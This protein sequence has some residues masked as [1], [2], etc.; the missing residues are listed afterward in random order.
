[1]PQGSLGQKKIDIAQLCRRIFL[2]NVGSLK[3]EVDRSEA[4]SDS[5][6]L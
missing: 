3:A 1:M 6:T 2:L 4:D 5:D